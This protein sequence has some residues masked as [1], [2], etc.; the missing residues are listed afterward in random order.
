MGLGTGFALIVLVLVA[1]GVF[2][3]WMFVD[4]IKSPRLTD[5][6][7]L[8]WCAGMLVIHPFVA[9]AYFVLEYQNKQR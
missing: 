2:E 1:I 8:L 3:I 7:K 9:I 4:A 5:S 6:R